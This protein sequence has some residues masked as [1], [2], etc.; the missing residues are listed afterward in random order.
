MPRPSPR[1]LGLGLLVLVLAGLAAV[2]VPI[3][4]IRP[5]TPQTPG[6][7]EVAFWIR[8]LAPLATLVLAALALAVAATLWRGARWWTRIALVVGPI[9]LVAAAWASRQN[10]YEQMFR[11]LP[12]T[13]SVVASAADWVAAADPVLAVTIGGEAAAYPVRQVSYH[14]VV[15]DVVGG[16][17]IVVTY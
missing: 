4:L 12:T 16:V 6:G 5:F 1:L 17:P 11:P 15:H 3:W 13:A 14:H 10:V 8:R 9:I 2:A 7:V